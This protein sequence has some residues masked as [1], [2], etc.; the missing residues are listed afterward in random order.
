[1]RFVL[2]FFAAFLA[3]WSLA[4]HSFAQSLASAKPSS[5]DF[6]LQEIS[7]QPGG[8]TLTITPS[9]NFY[10][11]LLG[12]DWQN[13]KS[14]GSITIKNRPADGT[15]FGSTGAKI[16][17]EYSF[18]KVGTVDDLLTVRLGCGDGDCPKS[19][20]GEYMEQTIL[21]PFH[22]LV[23]C[24]GS[25]SNC[26]IKKRECIIDR[27]SSEYIQFSV[28][29]YRALVEPAIVAFNKK[30]YSGFKSYTV[31]I[32]TFLSLTGLGNLFE[33]VNGVACNCTE[34]CDP[35]AICQPDVQFLIDFYHPE[36]ASFSWKSADGNPVLLSPKS[37]PI[38][39]PSL[40]LPASM[41]GMISVGASFVELFYSSATVSPDL[42][43]DFLGSTPDFPMGSRLYDGSV[44][45]SAT[46]LSES[47]IKHPAFDG[48][49]PN[50]HLRV[51]TEIEQP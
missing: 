30:Q 14:S 17:Y 19:D 42:T 37:N 4:S 48:K 24:T 18:G 16:D 2:L 36:S 49:P 28:P 9:G 45:C 31:P 5:V 1:M 20:N 27:Q 32:D 39:S 51:S 29:D 35:Q 12:I 50:I 44:L 3:C 8:G 25:G 26:S 34:Y 43:L 22:A 10:V 41:S 23:G 46:A 33:P 21:I 11:R 7:T 47:I 15:T 38:Y 6:G 40:R 13:G